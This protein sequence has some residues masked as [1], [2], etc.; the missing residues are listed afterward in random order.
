MAPV[1]SAV[2][3]TGGPESVEVLGW[4][5]K[6]RKVFCAIHDH[7]ERGG[8]QGLVYFALDSLR[9]SLPAR[10]PWSRG[11]GVADSVRQRKWSE[12]V[13]RLEPLELVDG[14]AI[15]RDSRIVATDTLREGD[16][17][18]LRYRVRVGGTR[19]AGSPHLEVATVFEPA[20]YFSRVYRIRGREETLVVLA[21]IGQLYDREE[22][23]VPVLLRDRDASPIRVE[24]KPWEP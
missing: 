8:P 7:S 9:Q 11:S 4:D 22:V 2:A 3:Y 18:G 12:I 19:I 14:P 21:F 24:W 20:V 1:P 5:P 10:V 17:S 6:E 13:R 23:Q 16:R 15:P